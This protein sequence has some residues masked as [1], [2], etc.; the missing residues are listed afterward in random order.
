MIVF[1]VAIHHCR[2]LSSHIVNIKV[3]PWATGF[4]LWVHHVRPWLGTRVC[5]LGLSSW[6][7]RWHQCC[8]WGWHTR[9]L[10]DSAA[11]GGTSSAAGPARGIC[12]CWW[13]DYISDEK[14]S[15]IC[16]TMWQSQPHMLQI[17]FNF[18]VSKFRVKQ[19]LSTKP[20]ID[21][22]QIFLTW[23]ISKTGESLQNWY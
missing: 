19:P 14:I 12:L 7:V 21:K 23:T 1:F 6:F 20:L 22:A 15:Q 4:L 8:P 10:W 16:V 9:L 18:T 13:S 3:H 17:P 5:V 11:P 2:V